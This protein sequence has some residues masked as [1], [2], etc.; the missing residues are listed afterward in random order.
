MMNDAPPL[1]SYLSTLNEV[2]AGVAEAGLAET[3]VL[4]RI[5][6]LDLLM[7]VHGVSERELQYALDM[8]E[9][10]QEL[11]ATPKRKFAPA[12]RPRLVRTA[13]MR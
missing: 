6:R 7:R 12:I 9:N 4:L 1:A 11:D 2:I 13:G 3:V 10:N 8:I 5:A